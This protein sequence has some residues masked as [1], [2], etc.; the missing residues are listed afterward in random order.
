[1]LSGLRLTLLVHAVCL[2]VFVGFA[3][4]LTASD[5]R[6]GGTSSEPIPVSVRD[7]PASWR[8]VYVGASGWRAPA[9]SGGGGYSFGK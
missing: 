1:M 4:L 2:A 5:F 7:N 9:T 6:F 8:P 3:F